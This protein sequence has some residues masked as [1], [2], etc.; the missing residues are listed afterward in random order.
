MRNSFL[1]YN[2]IRKKFTVF[3]EQWVVESAAYKSFNGEYS[4]DGLLW[5]W[6]FADS[7][8]RRSPSSVKATYEGVKRF[9]CTFVMIFT[10]LCRKTPT[11][12]NDVPRS[13]PITGPFI[14][15]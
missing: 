5:A 13:M 12:E 10:R 1:I 2:G 8:M 7:P 9:P 14:L 15:D 6:S 11:Q 3:L 4:I